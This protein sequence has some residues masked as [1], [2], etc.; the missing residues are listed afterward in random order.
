MKG[1]GGPPPQEISRNSYLELSPPNLALWQVKM[2]T[3]DDEVEKFPVLF[4]QTRFICKLIEKV[5]ERKKT[6]YFPNELIASSSDISSS[7]P[8]N[9]LFYQNFLN[10]NFEKALKNK[11][12]MQL[13]KRLKVKATTSNEKVFIFLMKEGVTTQVLDSL[14][15]EVRL[16]VF[17]ALRVLKRDFSSKFWE[18]LPK[19]GYELID[20]S[21]VFFN[22]AG[23]KSKSKGLK[24]QV[25]E[26]IRGNKSFE[27][28]VGLDDEGAEQRILAVN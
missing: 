11:K 10:N 16:G 13:F 1:R 18:K 22:L 3:R 2:L 6:T 9:S 19:K 12:R 20:R 4:R 8:T 14:P 5:V 21:D 27:E 15:S 25:S 26:I 7:L 24:A 28:E 17:E 23:R